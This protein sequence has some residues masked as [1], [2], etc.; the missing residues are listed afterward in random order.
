[1]R[2]AAA[3]QFPTDRLIFE[4]TENEQIVDPDHLAHIV[5]TYQKMGFG[6]AL[7]DFGAGHAGLALLARFQTDS[8]KLDRELIRGIDSSLSRRLIVEAMVRMCEGL[9]IRV[10]AEGVETE[11]ELT[12]LRGLGIR[13]AQGY[14]FARPAFERL[15]QASIPAAAAVAAA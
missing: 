4:F 7:D 9:R 6:T 8:V 13:Y 5:A 12:V 11:A 14:L 3:T 1:L 10:I 15:P 2:T